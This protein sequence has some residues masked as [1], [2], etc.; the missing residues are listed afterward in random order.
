MFEGRYQY[1][2]RV[3]VVI[4]ILHIMIEEHQSCKS[5]APLRVKQDDDRIV[6]SNIYLNTN[7]RLSDSV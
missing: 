5:N 7:L 6:Y 2:G 1:H 3:W 4:M